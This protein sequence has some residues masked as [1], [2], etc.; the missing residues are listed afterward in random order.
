MCY[1]IASC[2][3][4]SFIPKQ[5]QA[6]ISSTRV[7]QSGCAVLYYTYDAQL[8]LQPQ[9]I[10]H[11]EESYLTYKPWVFTRITQLTENKN[12][13]KMVATASSVKECILHMEHNPVTMIMP[14]KPR[15]DSLIPRVLYMTYVSSHGGEFYKVQGWRRSH[16]GKKW[17]KYR[18]DRALTRAISNQTE[19]T[20]PEN[21]CSQSPLQRTPLVKLC[22][23][24]F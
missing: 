18:E 15:C 23:C 24:K 16:R 19:T 7:L 10:H 14:Q 9:F 22:Y 17:Y 13:V 20:V 21:G 5:T 4:H 12:L 1:F 8:F 6:L 3:N 2:I 11:N